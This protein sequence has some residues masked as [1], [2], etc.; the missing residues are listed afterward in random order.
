MYSNRNFIKKIVLERI[1]ILFD[2]AEERINNKELKLAERYISRLRKMSSHYKIKIPKKYKNKICNRCN[3]I[4]IPGITCN[5]KIVS[6]HR[7]VS[8]ECKKCKKQKHLFY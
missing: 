8:Y 4:L 5:V 6:I 2:A 1:E 7:Y 3:L